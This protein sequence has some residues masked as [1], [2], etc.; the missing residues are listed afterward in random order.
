MQIDPLAEELGDRFAAAGFQL[1]LVGGVV[2]DAVL[3]RLRP[4]ADFDF[5]TDARP[6]ATSQI[7]RGWAE[8]QYL[9]GARYGTVGARK[10]G[11]RLEIT[12]FREEVYVPEDR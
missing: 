10:D 4:G 3:G 9:V 7:L 5:S 6:R 11:R 1:F 8:G 2:R 12:T